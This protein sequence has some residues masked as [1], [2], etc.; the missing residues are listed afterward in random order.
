MSVCNRP[1]H[2][3]YYIKVEK[4]KRILGNLVKPTFTCQFTLPVLVF[5]KKN[6][7]FYTSFTRDVLKGGD[8]SSSRGSYDSSIWVDERFREV[9]KNRMTRAYS[10]IFIYALTVDVMTWYTAVTIYSLTCFGARC[11]GTPYACICNLPIDVAMQ[12]VWYT[13]YTAAVIV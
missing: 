3:W 5:G 9:R 2:C 1:T 11:I 4:L 8:V 13:I 10:I 12:Y 6:E 7:Y